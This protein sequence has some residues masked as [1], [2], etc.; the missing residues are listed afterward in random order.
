MKF[1]WYSKNEH[2]VH[3]PFVFDLITKCFYNSNTHSNYPLFQKDDAKIQFLVR[4]GLYF[5]YKNSYLDAS[6]KTNF[7]HALNMHSVVEK[8]NTTEELINLSKLTLQLPSL[9]CINI[10]T[11]N[12][13]VL[14][15]FFKEC[16][17]DSIVLI[18]FLRKSKINYKSWNQL[19]SSTEVSVSIDTFNWGLLFFRT[20][21]LKEHFTIRL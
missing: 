18:P 5:G 19:K 8:F 21:Q 7:E 10:K 20:E 17:R 4:L 13:P 3:S 1:W 16:H 15:N 9:I 12:I 11:I 2:G 14:L 6:I